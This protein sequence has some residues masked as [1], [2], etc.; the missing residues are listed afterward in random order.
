[1]KQ[2][3]QEAKRMARIDIR[4]LESEKMQLQQKAADCAMTVTAYMLRAALG[5]QTRSRIDTQILVELRR[6]GGL[7]K[8]LFNE[9]GGA[10][11]KEFAAVLAE[12]QAAVARVAAK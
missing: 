12:I 1:M 6:L 8:H 10:M 11:S 7:Q 4:C 3:P 2:E 5:R 9:G